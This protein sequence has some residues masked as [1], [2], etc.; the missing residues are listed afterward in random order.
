[1]YDKMRINEGCVGM[2]TSI[3]NDKVKQWHKLKKK[4]DRVHE[5]EFLIEGFHLI[6]E[7]HASEWDIAEIILQEGTD[8]PDFL[9]N[10]PVVIVSTAVFH[11]IAATETPQGIA[12]IVH[13]KDQQWGVF[14]QV[15]ITDALQDPGNLGTMIRTAD[16]AGFD[17]VILGNNTVD[18]YNDKVIRSTQG[19][20]FHIPVFQENLMTK[21]LALKEEGF[22]IWASAL[23]HS[24]PFT[25]IKPAE[26][27]ALI[28]GNEG[29]GI[30]DKVLEL[31]DECVKIPI[32]GKAESLN[33]SVAA[34]ILMYYIQG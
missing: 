24:S 31:A 23:S 12:A 2:I 27:T 5:Q 13:M 11:H 29:S 30:E 16:A 15:L 7:V 28:V 9:T 33:A 32:H 4:K 22:V 8:A 26:K 19:S 34:G 1:M 6:E 21:I 3:Q 14:K 20:L 10:Y 17:A 18:M 25:V